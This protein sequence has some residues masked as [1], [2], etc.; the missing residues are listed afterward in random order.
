MTEVGL[1]L[2]IHLERQ[3][4]DCYDDCCDQSLASLFID[5]EQ[6]LELYWD[7]KRICWSPTLDL[8]SCMSRAEQSEQS[9]LR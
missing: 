2:F 5:I 9:S 7:E 1:S 4:L 8:D 3:E 6:G